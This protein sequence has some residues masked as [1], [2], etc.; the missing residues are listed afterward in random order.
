MR[1]V[2]AA[3]VE[4]LIARV[5]D[6]VW[7]TSAN[8]IHYGGP[9]AEG[10]LHGNRVVCPWH[11]AVF[12]VTTGRQLEP[13]G[14]GD[15]QSFPVRVEGGE[16]WVAVDAPSSATPTVKRAPG[17]DRLMVLVGAGAAGT[18]AAVTL[19]QQGYAGRIVLL[20]R[21]HRLPYDRTLLS[22]EVLQGADLPCPIELHPE[23]FY[24]E[25][26]IELRLGC[27]VRCLDAASR[28][29]NLVG[30]ETLRYDACLVATGGSPKRLSVPG[31]DL[32][33]NLHPAKLG[34]Q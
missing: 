25:H 11:H 21:E 20:S 15:L 3:G 2:T 10:A 33:G 4:I 26:S 8:C 24:R 16:V 7:A 5:G 28:T 34:G 13:P 30:D 12:D 17:D 27:E 23:R 9:L 32:R 6:T 1:Q 19:R 31:A 18:A 29:L 14:C 22:K